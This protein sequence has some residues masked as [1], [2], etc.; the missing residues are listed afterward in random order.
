VT[1]SKKTQRLIK[2]FMSSGLLDQQDHTVHSIPKYQLP[3]APNTGAQDFATYMLTHTSGDKKT[4]KLFGTSLAS[5][6]N[7]QEEKAG[8]LSSLF[9]A[10]STPLYSTAHFFQGMAE[11]QDPNKGF[12]ENVGHELKSAGEAV[13]GYEARMG[14]NA[15]GVLPG[16]WTPGDIKNKMAAYADKVSPKITG[17]NI[18]HENFGVKNKVARYG[19]GFA[20][21]L[22]MDP[23][24]YIGGFG[25]GGVKGAKDLLDVKA[26][27]PDGG[28]MQA[29]K[30]A[31]FVKD[32][33]HVPNI[34]FPG[35]AET[36][37]S[38][39][40]V[41]NPLHDS[42]VPK[43]KLKGPGMPQPLMDAI[44]FQPRTRELA[45]RWG[46]QEVRMAKDVEAGKIAIPDPARTATEK[47]VRA[48]K[49][50][51]RAMLRSGKVA[52]PS[53]RFSTQ[54]ANQIVNDILTGK[55]P[56]YS[57]QAPKAIGEPAQVARDLADNM[58]DNLMGPKR[59]TKEMPQ[60]T[61][62]F[63]K[64]G[65]VKEVTP[66]QQ[67]Q[68]YNKILRDGG[69]KEGNFEE[70]RAMLASAED[71]MIAL[72]VQPVWHNGVRVRL[73]DV[74]EATHGQV[75]FAEVL[76]DFTKTDTAKM[77]PLVR[78]AIHGLSAQ[79]SLT[80]AEITA[81]LTGLAEKARRE[82]LN[83]SPIERPAKESEIVKTSI[84]A[85]MQRGMTNKEIAAV[86][87]LVKDV[88]NV[89]KLPADKWVETAYSELKR[90]AI[91]GRV[92]RRLVTKFEKTIAESLG[93]SQKTLAT[94]ITGRH[95]V[96]QV[97][98]HMTTWWGKGDWQQI[99]KDVFDVGEENAVGRAKMMRHITL[100]YKPEEISDAWK[101]AT[102]LMEATDP[103][104]AELATFF[105]NYMR[106]VLKVQSHGLGLENELTKELSVAEKSMAQMEDINR[107]LKQMNG[108]KAFQF[109]NSSK[110]RDTMGRVR[111]YSKGSDWMTSWDRWGEVNDP[112]AFLYDIDLA[113][114][115]VTK[116]YAF[117]DSFVGAF[118]SV[119]QTATHNYYMNLSRIKG[120]GFL[121]NTESRSCAL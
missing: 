70:A 28:L 42:P 38:K 64:R 51:Q 86:K 10:L 58:I 74:I 30:A 8:V 85:A 5:R 47:L 90:A 114:E 44:K 104:S 107:T 98:T 20:L 72:G 110:A 82:L 35:T 115:R 117:L 91:E 118:G 41:A 2:H 78:S 45:R 116:E 94:D 26:A 13:V 50:W 55:S 46:Q 89:D 99:S 61:G 63:L 27:V 11:A 16:D 119:K 4:A 40:M 83:Y 3:S 33:K 113:M 15:L 7:A 100:T 59:A 6:T 120:L 95:V 73:S 49:D 37:V 69:L 101:H 96:D 1:T 112:V 56:R 92:D 23:T 54:S 17:Q 36:A 24:T 109:T 52:E 14:A 57:V 66:G 108:T 48:D 68:L 81:N 25:K 60:R 65:V 103:R 32:A 80:T 29:A 18:L 106:T 22:L 102:G 67:I 88:V 93:I 97:M 34:N 43:M 21:D 71:H 9:D 75:P 84:E 105:Q 12:M 76:K 31:P 53:G 19:G 39:R 87:D 79:R 121:R 111:D 77:N 62:S